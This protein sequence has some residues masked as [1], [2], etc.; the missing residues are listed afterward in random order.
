MV[1]PAKLAVIYPHPGSRFS[2]PEQSLHFG[3]IATAGLLL[4]CITLGCI[5]LARRRAPYLVAG[6]FWYLGMILPVIGLIQVGEQAIADRY[7]YLPSIGITICAV[8]GLWDLIAEIRKQKA[9]SRNGS[10]ALC[11]GCCGFGCAVVAVFALV[12]SR[13]L[14]YWQNTVTLFAHTI[15][16]TGPNPSAEFG[17]GV[18]LE[19]AGQIDE[20]LVHYR[21]AA[22]IDP[23]DKRFHYNLGQLLRKQEHWQEAADEYQIVLALDPTD[24][25]ALLNLAGTLTRLGRTEEAKRHYEEALRL[26]PASIEAAPEPEQC[27]WCYLCVCLRGL[28]FP[29]C[30]AGAGSSGYGWNALYLLQYRGLALRRPCTGSYGS[31]CLCR[32]RAFFRSSGDSAKSLRVGAEVG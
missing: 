8:W 28:Q 11:V 14:S 20:A 6:W 32:G 15:A 27:S 30:A 29:H 5:W 19:K 24:R 23:K 7:T 17:L 21:I 22:N 13:Q 16:V 18:G 9:E 10:K 1:W 2:G 25:D 3:Q 31:G 26:D 12:T 4:T